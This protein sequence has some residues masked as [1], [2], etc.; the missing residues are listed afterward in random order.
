M[1]EQLIFQPSAAAIAHTH[2][3]ADQYAALYERSVTDPD[4]FWAEQAKRILPA[5]QTATGAT[6]GPGIKLLVRVRPVFKAEYGFQLV[7]DAIDAEYTLG[8]L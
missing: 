3:N 7:I 2:T 4:G 6:I 1:S 8:D 5:F